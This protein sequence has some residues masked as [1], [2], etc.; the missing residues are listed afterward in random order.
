MERAKGRMPK[1]ALASRRAT[2][3]YSSV[4]CAKCVAL[5]RSKGGVRRGICR[6]C[7]SGATIGL[8]PLYPWARIQKHW[9]DIVAP[10]LEP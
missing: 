5:W 9:H 10:W 8:A 3:A 6:T 2:T 7:A 4:D 1:S